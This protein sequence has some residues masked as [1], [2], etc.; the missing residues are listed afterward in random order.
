[1]PRL[2][3]GLRGE[4]VTGLLEL[5]EMSGQTKIYV[6]Q[7]LPVHV[8]GPDSLDRLDLMLVEAGLITDADVA[9][10]RPS[11]RAAA[12]SWARC[13]ASW[14]WSAPTSWPRCCAGRCGARSP[15]PSP[16]GGQ[17]LHHRR[18]A[19]LR[20][21]Q[22]LAGRG[23]RSPHP[24]LPRDPGQLQREQARLRAGPAHGRMVRL[25]QV[26][27]TQLNELGFESRHSPCSCT[28]AWPASACTRPG[29][30]ARW[31]RARARP[32]R[33]SW[34]SSTSTCSR[35]WASRRP[36]PP[37]DARLG[38]PPMAIPSA[39]PPRDAASGSRPWS[40]PPPPAREMP[41]SGSRPMVIPPPPPPARCRLRLPPHGHPSSAPSAEMQASP[42]D[43]WR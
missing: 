21:Q 42:R 30:T 13:C 3:V 15:A 22:R 36:P 34:R 29:C 39:A 8:I 37:G 27:T 43:R 1:V 4:Q 24:G 11:A 23:G 33:C 10:P 14:A 28:C 17:L 41:A 38:L 26:S 25:R 31:G 19:P 6:R 18:R 16:R 9:R 20:A 2:L 35:C 32:R 40:S 7:G 5:T 12:A